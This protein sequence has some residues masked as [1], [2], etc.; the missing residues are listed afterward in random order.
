METRKQGLMPGECDAFDIASAHAAFSDWWNKD[1]LTARDHD[2]KRR[3]SSA[4]CQ[5]SALRYSPGM[6]DYFEKGSTAAEIYCELVRRYHPEAY[7]E[8]VAEHMTPEDDG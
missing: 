5:L 3:G 6:G 4:S 8:E 7:E 1:G 2:P